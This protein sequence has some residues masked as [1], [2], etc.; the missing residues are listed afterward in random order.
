[1]RTNRLRW[2]FD[3]LHNYKTKLLYKSIYGIFNSLLMSY[4]FCRLFYST[5]CTGDLG[6]FVDFRDLLT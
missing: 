1:M 6:F 2:N 5:F 3:D 4:I